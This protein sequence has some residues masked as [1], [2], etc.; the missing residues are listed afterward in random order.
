MKNLSHKYTKYSSCFFFGLMVLCL[1]PMA[2]LGFYTHPLGDDFYYSWQTAKAW[3]ETGNIFEVLKIACMGV[4]EQYQIWQGTYSAMF[5]MHLSPHIWGEIFQKMYPTVLL[6]CFVGSTFYLTHCLMRK[7]L[8]AT[9]EQWVL[10]TS[11]LVITFTQQVPL[12]GESLY[13][14]NG[15]MYYT[16]F[17]AAT[18]FFW[19]YLLKTL[20]KP[21]IKRLIVLSL[22]AIFLAGGNYIS[23]LPT[24]ILLVLFILYYGYQIIQKQPRHKILLHLCVITL[25]MLGGFVVSAVA[26]GNALRA[27]TANQLS[28][29]KAVLMSIYQN[30][31][32][33]LYWNGIWSLLLFVLV[34][35]VF[36]S[37]AKS[38]TWKFRYPVIVCGLIF[39]I[40]CSTS[41][42]PF[43]AQSNGGAA[44]AFCLVYYM[45][46]LALAM[47]YFYAIGAVCRLLKRQNTW[48]VA[49]INDSRKILI[50][51]GGLITIFLLLLFVRPW[52]ETYVKPHAVTA[53]QVLTNGDA[54]YYEAQY[55]ERLAILKDDSIK[56]VVFSPYDVPDKLQYMIHLGDIGPDVNDYVNRGIAVTY[57]KNSVKV[58]Y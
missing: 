8:N 33:C 35:P 34:T 47:I 1:V 22:L 13:W 25:F 6:L 50:I 41:C 31:R 27:A 16:G 44:R 32:Y 51:Q 4:A 5:L 7:Y 45:M 26:P 19:G 20:S 30:S 46:I 2:I 37:I 43:Y 38:S 52:N 18:F 14:Y 40:Y 24:M 3:H 10:V 17:L 58:E 36:W 28:P 56:D 54:A 55:Q 12:C 57:E 39:G 53:V 23:L 21:T 29:F 42:P 9:K 15:S 11:L 48:K 49:R